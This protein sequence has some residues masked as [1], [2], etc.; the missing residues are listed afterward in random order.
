M[1]GCRGGSELG[2]PGSTWHGMAKCVPR[3]PVR[4]Q[5]EG[6]PAIRDRAG[7]AGGRREPSR[8]ARGRSGGSPGAGAG[9]EAAA[10]G[11]PR[12]QAA[13]AEVGRGPLRL[14]P[15]RCNYRLGTWPVGPPRLPRPPPPAGLGAAQTFCRSPRAGEWGSPRVWVWGVCTGGG[16]LEGEPRPWRR[17]GWEAETPR[18]EL[19]PRPPP[20][21]T[22]PPLPPTRQ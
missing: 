19:R 15:G 9:A 13:R 17:G 6:K 16:G 1:R 14:S 21:G 22:A 5:R 11:A 20:L 2:G 4:F 8:S 3:S 18:Q 7:R 12:R 10:A